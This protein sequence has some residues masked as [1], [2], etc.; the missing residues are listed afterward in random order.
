MVAK[1]GVCQHLLSLSLAPQKPCPEYHKGSHFTFFMPLESSLRLQHWKVDACPKG[2][3]HISKKNRNHNNNPKVL[4]RCYQTHTTTNILIII[5]PFWLLVFRRV[6]YEER[7]VL[8][9]NLATPKNSSYIW[10]QTW[11]LCMDLEYQRPFSGRVEDQGGGVVASLNGP[12]M[13]G[14]VHTHNYSAV[15]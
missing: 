11:D 2:S 3:L 1:T 12:W 4:I 10:I 14:Y 9:G 15:N 8:Q 7:T 6:L 13:G 5:P